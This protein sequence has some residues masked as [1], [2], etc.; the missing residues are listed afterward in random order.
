[1]DSDR[2]PGPDSVPLEQQQAPA[3]EAQA[4]KS[5]L[6]RDVRVATR[7]GR[8]ALIAALCAAIVS[9]AVSAG[10]A[11]YVSG[12]QL[13]RNE[14]LAV[15]QD[16]RENRQEAYAEFVSALMDLNG[17]LGALKGALTRNPP[18]REVVRGIVQ[19]LSA[20]GLATWTAVSKVLLVGNDGLEGTV[21]KFADS[22]TPFFGD[23]LNPFAS[24]NLQGEGERDP[25]GLLR[26]GPPL[27][28]EI[29]RLIAASGD[30][31]TSFLDQAREDLGAG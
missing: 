31:L 10:S 13:D 11:L 25:D 12:N 15:A 1:M 7:S 24:R 26:D 5:G 18:D 16:V 6:E 3:A 27:I 29:D 9:S 23:H 22:Y 2:Q 4:S 30:I 28:A 14:R 19:G 17:G 8:Y 21:G 20:R